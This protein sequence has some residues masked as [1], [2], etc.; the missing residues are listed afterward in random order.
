MFN[1]TTLLAD[2]L[3]RH[4]AETYERIYGCR[5]PEYGRLLDAAGKLVI[6]QIANSDALYHNSNHTAHATLVGE[7]VLRGTLAA[8]ACRADG[9]FV[10]FILAC[11]RT[12]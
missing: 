2:A 1:A 12:T 6:E 5:E 9:L 4:L 7:A 10:H 8:T 11:S 3:G